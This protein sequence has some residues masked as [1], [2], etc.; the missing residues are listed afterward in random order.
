MS[1]PS[2]SSFRRPLVAAATICAVA[3]V[4]GAAA[5]QPHGTFVRASAASS[6]PTPTVFASATITGA[7]SPIVASLW[8]DWGARFQKMHHPLTVQDDPASGSNA[9]DQWTKGN[10]AVAVSDIIPTAA[11][12]QA[13]LARCGSSF[14]TLPIAVEPMV[15]AYNLP[16]VA[17]GLRLTPDLVAGIV[18]G[19]VQSWTNERI[20]SLNPG[21]KLPFRAINL[22]PS[23]DIADGAVLDQ[24]LYASSPLWRAA[25]GANNQIVRAVHLGGNGFPNISALLL[26]TPDSIAY[27][28]L[29]QARAE[30]LTTVSLPDARGEFVVAG[31]GA[32]E[33]SAGSLTAKRPLNM[34]QT[35]ASAPARRAYPLAGY[36]YLDFCN[37]Q[38]GVR[39]KALLAFARYLTGKG[40]VLPWSNG[41]AALPRAVRNG[42]L[43]TLER[44]AA[45]SAKP[46]P[47]S[48]PSTAPTRRPTTTITP[49]V[50]ATVASAVAPTNTMSPTETITTTAMPPTSTAV[51]TDT[52]V[53]TLTIAPTATST[54]TPT[55]TAAPTTTVTLTA[56][57]VTTNLPTSTV[58][59]TTTVMSTVGTRTAP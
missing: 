50:T 31:L 25:T 42:D 27:L 7:V 44:I 43:L 35:L 48:H 34:R 10:D 11:E 4:L 47:T 30:R 3:S 41:L 9:W 55:S 39:G 46:L 12:Q 54:A 1:F 14:V 56:T 40:A 20:T 37:R 49:P 2:C 59:A 18:L 32:A 45:A 26:Q 52:T 5:S 29:A 38:T 17:P 24:Y 23:P 22:L 36:V 13:A 58:T 57:A 15:L 53:P 28:S 19:T 8:D 21:A 33:A 16:R 51:L 6:R